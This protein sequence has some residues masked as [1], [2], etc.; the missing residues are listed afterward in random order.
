LA[1][2]LENSGPY[3]AARLDSR[4]SKGEKA[5]CSASVPLATISVPFPKTD[6]GLSNFN[7]E[8][9]MMKPVKSLMKLPPKYS[10]SGT[11]GRLMDLIPFDLRLSLASTNSCPVKTW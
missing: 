9:G 1:K 4:C 7:F 2:G 8:K 6:V 11:L 10:G 5:N 3:S